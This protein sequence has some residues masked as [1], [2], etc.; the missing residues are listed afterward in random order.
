MHFKCLFIKSM[1]LGDLDTSALVSIPGVITELPWNKKENDFFELWFP[2]VKDVW[3]NFQRR[4]RDREIETIDRHNRQTDYVCSMPGCRA[5]LLFP[6]SLPNSKVQ[7]WLSNWGP[8]RHH[9]AV[10]LESILFGL[11]GSN[12]KLSCH[13]WDFYRLWHKRQLLAFCLL[14][15]LQIPMGNDVRELTGEGLH[16]GW[17][18]PIG[19]S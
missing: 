19:Q 3:R 6:C 18:W 12:S 1:F 10:G 13:L 11:Q 15:Q 9:L 4:S 5:S 14:Y 16:V 17:S 7:S 8:Q 2:S